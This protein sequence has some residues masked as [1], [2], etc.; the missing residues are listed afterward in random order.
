VPADDL[1]L[2]P[3]HAEE[4]DVLAELPRGDLDLGAAFAQDLDER[5]EHEHVR[6]TGD[7]DP[8]PHRP[9]SLG[10]VGSPLAAC[11]RSSP[12]GAAAVQGQP[13]FWPTCLAVLVAGWVGGL[14]VGFLW[15]LFGTYG[16][17]LE[18]MRGFGATPQHVSLIEVIGLTLIAQG[19]LR[20]AIGGLVLPRVLRWATGAEISWLASA[21]ALGV[22]GLVGQGG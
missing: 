16:A 11:C 13:G 20:A 21:L 6:R 9:R 1:G 5:P 22:G 3:V 17:T 7:V 14:A 15:G 19:L 4:L 8:D 18:L 12:H 2:H 10:A